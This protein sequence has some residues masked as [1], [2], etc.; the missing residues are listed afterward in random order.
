MAK[1]DI[2]ELLRQHAV[3][4]DL[5]GEDAFRAKAF[6]NAARLLDISDEPLDVL[7]AEHRVASLRGIGKS[8]AAVIEE[9]A[10]SGTFAEHE[11]ARERVPVGVLDLLRVEGLGP[12]KARILWRV[13]NITSLDE[14]EAALTAGAVDKLSGFGGKTAQKF[15]ASLAFLKTTSG[16]HWRHRAA[17]TM[18]E[19]QPEL[20]TIQGIDEIFIGGSFRRG[21]E[22]IGDLDVV[23]IAKQEQHHAIRTALLQ[24]SGAAWKETGEIFKGEFN[25]FPVEVSVAM[26]EQAAVVKLLATGSKEHVRALKETAAKRGLELND[27]A[28]PGAKTEAEIYAALGLEFVPPP[29][30]ET[31]DTLAAAGSRSFPTALAFEDIKGILHCHTTASDGRNNLQAMAE[32]MIARGLAFLGIADHS[33]AAAYARG[34]TPERIREQWQ[35]I[36]RLNAEL[37]PFRILKGTEV[38]IQAGGLLDFDDDLL[39][40]FDFVIA[41]VHSGFNMTE[42]EA[43]ERVCRALENPH[44]DIL[45]HPTG[46]L[47]LERNGYPLNHERVIACAAQNGKAIEFNC[48]P[49]RFDLDWRWLGLCEELH[50]P[51]PLCPDAHDIDGLWDIRY[52]VDVAAKGPL[53]AVNCPSTWSAEKFVDW[54]RSHT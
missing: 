54:C 6:E 8:L 39:A 19:L 40:G 52:G 37:K 5:L 2:S 7:I 18:E 28:F 42:G 15:L 10:A 29:L 20:K 23:L 51:V 26:P 34:L 36:D 16:R 31:A 48:N 43:T 11:Q 46:R 25:A 38:D 4:L 12:K 14:L 27:T 9:I 50:V 32:A 22:T 17:R 41:S 44:V 47:L 35:E 30:R 33:Q 21:C 45:G 53:T 13:A 49:H 3:L 24:L 1:T